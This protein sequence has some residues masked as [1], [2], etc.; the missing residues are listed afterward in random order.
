MKMLWR[1]TRWVQR[2]QQMI[3]QDLQ[4]QLWRSSVCSVTTWTQTLVP[5]LSEGLYAQSKQVGFIC[6]AYFKDS[7]TQ[8]CLLQPRI[9]S[10]QGHLVI[11]CDFQRLPYSFTDL[12]LS[13]HWM[14]ESLFHLSDNQHQSDFGFSISEDKSQGMKQFCQYKSIYNLYHP[15]I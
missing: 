9:L 7:C 2:D 14:E 13:D 8:K 12:N 15:F 1:Q 10:G 5:S 3:M 4:V 6:E 11:L